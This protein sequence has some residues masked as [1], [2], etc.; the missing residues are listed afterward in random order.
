MTWRFRVKVLGELA[1]PRVTEGL[2]EVE[3]GPEGE[4]ESRLMPAE[5]GR[6]VAVDPSRASLVR[7]APDCFLGLLLLGSASSSASRAFRCTGTGFARLS[8]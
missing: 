4:G 2:P 7:A 3:V 1:L 6:L 5:A 8:G